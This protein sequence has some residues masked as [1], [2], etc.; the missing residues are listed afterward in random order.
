MK[1]GEFGRLYVHF[2]AIVI[3][4]GINELKRS[5]F[6]CISYSTIHIMA[7]YMGDL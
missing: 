6:I 7:L 2:M 5:Y 3:S 1:E 4:F